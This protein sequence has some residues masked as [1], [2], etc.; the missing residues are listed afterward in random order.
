MKIFLKICHEILLLSYMSW[1]V[2]SETMFSTFG[3]LMTLNMHQEASLHSSQM[4]ELLGK[5]MHPLPHNS[6]QVR[7]LVIWC[8]STRI[9]ITTLIY[10]QK[11]DH[12]SQLTWEWSIF[13][14]LVWESLPG[15]TFK[16]Q[17][18][19]FV[20]SQENSERKYLGQ[21]F[22]LWYELRKYW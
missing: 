16:H 20:Y 21:V 18:P 15:T 5:S 1:A 6:T 14:I 17:F 12:W 10:H 19:Q 3:A 7:F 4:L 13:K 11:W 9:V 22:Y 2:W 8:D